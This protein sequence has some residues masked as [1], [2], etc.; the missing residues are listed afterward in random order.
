MLTRLLLTK[1]PP[2]IGQKSQ[3]KRGTLY[4]RN[5]GERV[6]YTIYL[7]VLFFINFGMDML[8]L[9]LTAF[10]CRQSIAWWRYLLSPFLGSFLFV[11]MIWLP[12]PASWIY[13]ICSYGIIGLL[14]SYVAFSPHSIRRILLCYGCQLLITI[15]LG[16]TMNW[17]YFST[18]FGTWLN[19]LFQDQGL[20]LGEFGILVLVTV[21]ILL[22]L[23]TGFRQ[24]R[25]REN[26][27]Y[28][29][30]SLYF[31]DK[32]VYGTG[33]VDTGNFLTEPVTGRPVV[34]AEAEWLLPI[35]SEDYQLLVNRY[36]EQKKLDYDLIAEKKLAKAKWIPY[37][38]L[39]ENRGEL[40]GIQC[41]RL[42]LR[43]G[44]KCLVRGPVIVGIS[45][46]ISGQKQYQMLLHTALIEQ[47]E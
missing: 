41:T 11:L 43:K 18:P 47:E 19:Q 26:R 44:R 39:G 37:Q 29:Q 14:M 3:V 6:K 24:Y 34:V 13:Y 17:L 1:L 28:Y 32:N 12:I 2:T 10:I 4:K 23:T 36:L 27:D 38:S 31:E 15:L 35:L 5:G 16:G 8:I 42:V 7:D 40:L 9:W 30:L 21:V 25:S 46:T 45:E 20:Q 33:L 22:I